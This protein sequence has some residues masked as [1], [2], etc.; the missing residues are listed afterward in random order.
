MLKNITLSAEELL[1]QSAR[2]KARKQ[3][4]SLNTLFRQWLG[5]YI[6]QDER[7]EA[8]DNLVKRVSYIRAGKHFSRE[9]MNER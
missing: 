9:E 7:A 5:N 3:K 4:K 6:A 2:D 1:I 8:F